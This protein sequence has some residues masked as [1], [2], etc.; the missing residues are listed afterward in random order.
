M[1]DTAGDE[2]TADTAQPAE[3]V[4]ARSA[5]DDAVIAPKA[6]GLP[7]WGVALLAVGGALVVIGVGLFVLGSG[8]GSKAP[9]VAALKPFTAA[10]AHFRAGFPTP[11][12]RSDQAVPAAGQSI[13]LVQYTSEVD[14]DTGYSIGWFQLAQ[15]PVPTGVRAFLEATERGSVDAIRGRLVGPASF[16][17]DAAGHPAVDYLATVSG[18][19]YVKSRTV[20]VGRDVYVLQVVSTAKQPPRYAEFVQAFTVI[21]A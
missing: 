4:W 3:P 5:Q 12:R 1:T 20:L 6:A 9:H 13:R 14:A 21:A 8:G 11:P 15:A 2:P 7:R 18:G 10:D 19:H 17:T 16:V